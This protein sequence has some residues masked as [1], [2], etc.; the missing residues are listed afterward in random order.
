MATISSALFDAIMAQESSGK[1]DAVGDKG[2]AIGPFQIHEVYWKDAVAYD[3]SLTANKETYQ[4]CKGPGSIEYSK[5][6]MQAYM[7]RYAGSS[8]TDED[9]ARIHNGGPKG[10]KN[11]KTLGYWKKVQS[12]L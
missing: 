9:I 7:N 5:R 8:P 3:S 11:P 2:A 6:V 1:V 12:H 10:H 4:S